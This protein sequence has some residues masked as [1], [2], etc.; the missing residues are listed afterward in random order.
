M[1]KDEGKYP[2]AKVFGILQS[3]HRLL[4]EE[5]EGEHSKG[6]GFYYRPIGGSIEYGEKSTEALS[7]EFNEELKETVEIEDF[8]GFI[9]NIFYINDR[10]GHEIILIYNVSFVDKENYTR[11][12]FTI[13]E[14]E[15]VSFAK[16]IDVMDF[17]TGKKVLFPDGLVDKLE[18][19]IS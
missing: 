10:I 4:V 11:E 12:M 8:L 9:E 15:Q 2:R 7:R 19:G 13:Q 16:W 3:G 1:K 18:R 14:S 6:R 17:V 5:F